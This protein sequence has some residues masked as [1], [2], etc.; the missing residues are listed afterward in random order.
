MLVMKYASGGDL[1]KYL[2]RNFTTITWNRDKL[3]ILWQISE[4]YLFI[5]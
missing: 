5:F 4:G 2:Q 1:H 3:N